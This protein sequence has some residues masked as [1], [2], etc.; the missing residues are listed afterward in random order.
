MDFMASV[1]SQSVDTVKLDLAKEMMEHVNRV[2]L[3]I[4]A[5]DAIKCVL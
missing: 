1:V 2:H 3:D 4:M 5:I